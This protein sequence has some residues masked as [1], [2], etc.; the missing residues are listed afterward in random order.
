[1]TTQ[2][3]WGLPIGS[4]ATAVK[5]RGGRVTSCRGQYL[6]EPAGAPSVGGLDRLAAHNLVAA[7]AGEGEARAL[8]RRLDELAER[9]GRGA[10]VT[11]HWG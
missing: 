1:M 3:G 9:A 11:A 4:P 6:V 8:F 2:Q 5:P 10:S 7:A